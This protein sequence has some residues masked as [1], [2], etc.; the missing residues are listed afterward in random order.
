[1][2]MESKEHIHIITYESATKNTPTHTKKQR[3]L[4]GR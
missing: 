2:S 3:N 1:M 4:Q